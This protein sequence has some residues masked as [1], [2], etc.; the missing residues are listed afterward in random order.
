MDRVPNVEI[1]QKTKVD[2][3]GSDGRDICPDETRNGGQEDQNGSGQI[4][5][6]NDLIIASD[7]RVLA[8]TGPR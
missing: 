6:P 3:V 7:L 1:Q 8:G 4:T 5:G 2:D